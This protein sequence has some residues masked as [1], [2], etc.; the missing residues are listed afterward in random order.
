MTHCQTPSENQMM[1]KSSLNCRHRCLY[2]HKFHS[3][4]DLRFSQLLKAGKYFRVTS[5]VKKELQLPEI[6]SVSI[7]SVWWQG[8]TLHFA[9]ESRY[10]ENTVLLWRRCAVLSFVTQNPD[11]WNRDSLQNVACEFHLYMPDSP[12]RNNCTFFL[13]VLSYKLAFG[14]CGTPCILFPI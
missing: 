5:L 12:K 8:L 14:T 7:I 3:M 4:F 13:L 2:C 11:A 10:S 9:L 6:F 1:H